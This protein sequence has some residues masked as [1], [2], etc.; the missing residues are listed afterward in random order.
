M[1]Q[2]SNPL[3]PVN[4]I[5]SQSNTKLFNSKNVAL[6]IKLKYSISITSSTA[7]ISTFYIMFWHSVQKKK[8]NVTCAILYMTCKIV[9]VKVV[10]SPIPPSSTAYQ[11]PHIELLWNGYRKCYVDDVNITLISLRWNLCRFVAAVHSCVLQC[12]WP[13]CST[14]FSLSSIVQWLLHFFNKPTLRSNSC[15]QMRLCHIAQL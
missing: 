11:H 13:L 14:V 10:N 8:T 15:S 2:P 5:T 6:S 12:E 9:Q 1:N 7:K 3:S 4:L